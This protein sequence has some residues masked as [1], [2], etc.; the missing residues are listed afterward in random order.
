MS[1]FPKGLTFIKLTELL[2]DAQR[3]FIILDVSIS[4]SCK[5]CFA[6]KV[7]KP[8]AGKIQTLTLPISGHLTAYF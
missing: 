5:S 1:L 4:F 6:I 3:T 7:Q 2:P 8:A